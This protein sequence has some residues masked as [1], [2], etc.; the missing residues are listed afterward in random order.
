VVRI[1]NADHF[2]FNSNEKQVIE[3][4]DRFVTSLPTQAATAD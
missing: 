2:V 1:A 4:I 3:E